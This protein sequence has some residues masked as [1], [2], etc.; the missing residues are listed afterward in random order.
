[1]G[2]AK[3]VASRAGV[4][5]QGHRQQGGWWMGGW[6]VGRHKGKQIY[7]FTLHL[8]TREKIAIYWKLGGG[9]PALNSKSMQSK[10]IL[11]RIFERSFRNN[12]LSFSL[13]K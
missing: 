13:K 8:I 7:E 11:L 4:E 9:R 10:K 3:R 1:M 6:P 5:G 12:P 2:L